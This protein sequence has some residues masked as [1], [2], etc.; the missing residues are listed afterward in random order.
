MFSCFLNYRAARLG[1]SLLS[2]HSNLLSETEWV[3]SV[4]NRGS[5]EVRYLDTRAKY[6]IKLSGR[7][8]R[9]V[10]AEDQLQPEQLLDIVPTV[11]LCIVPVVNTYYDRHRTI[12]VFL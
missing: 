6:S 8:H 10:E 4:K 12:P 1:A 7:N 3:Y 11:V 2:N 9:G 5:G